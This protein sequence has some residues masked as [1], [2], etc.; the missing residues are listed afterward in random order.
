MNSINIPD[1][2]TAVVAAQK[3][4]DAEL[5]SLEYT[6]KDNAEPPTISKWRLFRRKRK[7]KELPDEAEKAKTPSV[8]YWE[9]YKCP[10]IASSAFFQ[11]PLKCIAK[12]P[13]KCIIIGFLTLLT[14]TTSLSLIFLHRYADR[15][16][17]LLIFFGSLGA[18]AN[19]VTLPM[20]TFVF[21][22]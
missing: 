22:K 2:N 9:L 20:F 6:V 12:S 21:G 7:K 16:D 18:I 14:R 15:T 19:G 3:V 11:G 4:E 8:A 17:K 5:A 13:H 1:T 10:S